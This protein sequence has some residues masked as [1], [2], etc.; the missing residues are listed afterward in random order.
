[1]GGQKR[2]IN[3]GNKTKEEK[4]MKIGK[5]MMA[6]ALVS[7]LLVPG[8]TASPDQGAQFEVCASAGEG[9]GPVQGF[10][11]VR[12][13][14]EGIVPREDQDHGISR[15]RAGIGCRGLFGHAGRHHRLHADE[16]R[17]PGRPRQGP[18]HVRPAVSVQ[19]RTGS[20][21]HRRRP[22]RQEGGREA[23]PERASW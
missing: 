11:M 10:A 3:N 14:R 12:G 13:P 1:M 5:W 21:F 20:G 9:D 2:P 15:G 22:G 8:V 6:G 16:H 19:Q 23:A 18:E 4:E 7:A 17:Q